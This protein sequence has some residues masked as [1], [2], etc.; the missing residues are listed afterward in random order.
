VSPMAPPGPPPGRGYG[1]VARLFHWITAL[2]VFLMI[3]V[4]I[5]MTS[6]GFE[7]QGDLLYIVHKGTGSVLLVLVSMRILWKLLHPVTPLPPG[8]PPLQRRIAG[9][10]HWI[11]LLLLLTMTL[12]GYV[13]TVGEGFPIELL[14][15]LGI[16]P[17]VDEDAEL[18]RRMSVL[19]KF[20]AYTLAAFIAAH[21]GAATHQAIIVRDGV[22]GRIW[23]PVRPRDAGAGGEE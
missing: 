15:A 21:V 11:L 16:P 14:D 19:H 17:L 7:R 13:R 22:M 3:P 9:A 5:A 10:T 6:Q 20:T 8:V 1:T 18:A 23:P 2:L 12:S 4:G